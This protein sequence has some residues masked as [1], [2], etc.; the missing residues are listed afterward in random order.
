MCNSLPRVPQ[1][2]EHPHHAPII[3]VVQQQPLLPGWLPL[4]VPVP[5]PVPEL[6]AL[7]PKEAGCPVSHHTDDA[8]VT[9]IIVCSPAALGYSRQ[10]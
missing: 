7:L 1:R 5:V 4:P 9:H 10:L 3:T 2:H 8:N 6:E